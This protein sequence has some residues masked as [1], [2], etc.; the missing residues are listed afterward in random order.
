MN[1]INKSTGYSPF[2]LRFGRSPR[3]M[4]PIIPPPPNP[5]TEY[6]NA[7]AIIEEVASNVADARDNL[8]LA[9][10]TQSFHSNSSRTD[11][12]S[13]KTGDKVMLSTLNRWK[14]YKSQG[15][16]H[17]AKFMPRFNGPYLVVNTHEDASTVTLD[18]PNVPNIF[19]TFHTSHIKPFKQ[20][21][22]AKWP[23]RTLEKPGP[24]LINGIPEHVIQKIIDQKK[25][26]N[27]ISNTLFVGAA[28]V[29]KMIN[30]FLVVIWTT[31]SP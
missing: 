31:T 9:K 22:N 29:P 16:V 23:A 4:P 11:A 24:I 8:M 21:D 1:T 5:S 12:T 3:A 6:I 20:N 10:I 14:E 17:V 27:Q 18:I 25:S 2:Q 19:P 28:T 7:R 13:Y 15:E 26:A 30:G